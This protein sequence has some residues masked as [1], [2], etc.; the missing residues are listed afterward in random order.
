MD[1]VALQEMLEKRLNKKQAN[2]SLLLKIQL[3]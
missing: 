2:L 3:I 1:V